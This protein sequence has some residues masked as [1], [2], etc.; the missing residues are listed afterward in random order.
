MVS[1]FED[2][3]VKV[4][5]LGYLQPDG[6]DRDSVHTLATNLLTSPLFDELHGDVDPSDL[7]NR[8]KDRVDQIDH[9]VLHSMLELDIPQAL[10]NI[11]T[12]MEKQLLQTQIRQM[13][14]RYVECVDIYKQLTQEWKLFLDGQLKRIHDMK[15]EELVMDV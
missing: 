13:E 5:T 15:W 2:L 12:S 14:M 6:I 1:L 7:Q 3:V 9:K 10:S 8:A 11:E 4:Y